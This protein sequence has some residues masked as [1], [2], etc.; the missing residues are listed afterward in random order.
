[1]DESVSAFSAVVGA[2]Y[3][4]AEDRIRNCPFV[5]V[6]WNGAGIGAEP[7]GL[8]LRSFA[9]GS[10]KFDDAEIRPLDVHNRDSASPTDVRFWIGGEGQISPTVRGAGDRSQAPCR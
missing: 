9:A 3:V 6:G 5:A 4:K 10:V 1:M 8:L 7:V 2:R